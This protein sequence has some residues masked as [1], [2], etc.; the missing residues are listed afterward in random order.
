MLKTLEKAW[1]RFYWRGTREDLENHIR[2]CSSC[3]EVNDPSKLPK[4]H[5]INVKSGHPLQRVAI[6]IVG[7]T[8][9]SSSGHKWLLVVPIT[10]LNLPRLS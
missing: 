4:A 10:L 9:R 6:E 5:L 8:P 2:R 7:P 1:R 3:A